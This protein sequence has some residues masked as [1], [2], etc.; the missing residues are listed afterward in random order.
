MDFVQTLNKI[1]ESKEIWI[2]E[3]G[4]N[5]FRVIVN[6]KTAKE[7]TGKTAKKDA[8]EF[9]SNYKNKITEATLNSQQ[10]QAEKARLAAKKQ[11][12]SKKQIT[13]DD[14]IEVDPTKP[15]TY[16]KIDKKYVMQAK[17]AKLLP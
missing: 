2:Q 10:V 4:L 8:E 12:I 11:M 5:E 6:G 16:R 17:S 3:T 13:P 15:N 7:F 1:N 9:V 14:D